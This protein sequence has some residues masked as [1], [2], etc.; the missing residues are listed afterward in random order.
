MDG[1]RISGQWATEW[2]QPMEPK[3]LRELSHLFSSC[4]ALGIVENTVPF[5][6]LAPR[7]G[8]Y[9]RR[10]LINACIFWSCVGR[11]SLSLHNSMWWHHNLLFLARCARG[12]KMELDPDRLIAP[13]KK[14]S[15]R[16]CYSFIGRSLILY[17]S[18][19][20]SRASQPY[21][22]FISS[23]IKKN[24]AG[25]QD[26]SVNLRIKDTLRTGQLSLVER[27]SSFRKFPF[28]PIGYFF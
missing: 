19:V 17:G 26:Y 14:L 20:N 8:A 7:M 23:G 4:W 13:K 18:S 2:L 25:S 1:G 3:A 28:K 24:T 27:L 11:G 16:A 9:F 22:F 12:S 6:K 15:L 21:F 5:S 10:A